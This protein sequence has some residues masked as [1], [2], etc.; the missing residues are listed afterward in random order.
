VAC[1]SPESIAVNKTL[2]SKTI[3]YLDAPPKTA[4]TSVSAGGCR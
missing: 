1:F 4:A 3:Y 2:A